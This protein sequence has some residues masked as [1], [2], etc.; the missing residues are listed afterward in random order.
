MKLFCKY[1][2]LFEWRGS[3]R[4]R[5][6]W[7]YVSSCLKK[8]QGVVV[9]WDAGHWE[10]SPQAWGARRRKQYRFLSECRIQAKAP[11]ARFGCERA[12]LDVQPERTSFSKS[13]HWADELA[14][15]GDEQNAYRR[16]ELDSETPVNYLLTHHIGPEIPHRGVKF[17]SGKVICFRDDSPQNKFKRER[18]TRSHVFGL[19]SQAREGNGLSSFGVGSDQQWKR[20]PPIWGYPR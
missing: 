1:K 10:N 20:E 3:K 2:F 8:R 14:R 19:S 17:S 15:L 9:E 18:G 12:V 6:A 16:A 13:W 5:N 11:I 7:E 4:K